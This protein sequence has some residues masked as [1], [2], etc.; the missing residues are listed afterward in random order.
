MFYVTFFKK[1]TIYSTFEAV[2][3]PIDKWHATTFRRMQ[4]ETWITNGPFLYIKEFIL[5]KWLFRGERYNNLNIQI[6]T[7]SHKKLRNLYPSNKVYI[8]NGPGKGSEL[9]IEFQFA[10]HFQF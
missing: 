6:Q 5:R 8:F 2:Y 4:F 3:Q 1:Y 10:E 7:V 9:I